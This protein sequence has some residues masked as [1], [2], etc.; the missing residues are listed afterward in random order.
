M[1]SSLES[2]QPD[3]VMRC[4]QVGLL[5]VQEDTMDRPT[6]SAIVVMLSGEASL[7]SPM[8]PAFVFRKNSCDGA[9]PSIPKGLYSDNDLTISN[10]E[11]R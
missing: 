7:P 2:Y 10:V 11:G 6:M 1:D 3:E 4:I 8:Q 9:D 5:C